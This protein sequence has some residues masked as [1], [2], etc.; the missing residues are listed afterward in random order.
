MNCSELRKELH[1]LRS[2]MAAWDSSGLVGTSFS[3]LAKC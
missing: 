2:D 3:G 1:Q